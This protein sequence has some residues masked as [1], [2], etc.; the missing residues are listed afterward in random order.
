MKGEK[1][2]HRLNM[3]MAVVGIKYRANASSCAVCLIESKAEKK[4]KSPGRSAVAF[5]AG[6]GMR[7]VEMVQLTE[8]SGR[9]ARKGRVCVAGCRG[10]GDGMVCRP[11]TNQS[12]DRWLE[13]G[14]AG[15]PWLSCA[16][17]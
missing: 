8:L 15:R 10:T 6:V 5:R 9:K 2:G 12:R 17:I 7:C 16:Q 3:C 4:E 13:R 11:W 14:A 1:R